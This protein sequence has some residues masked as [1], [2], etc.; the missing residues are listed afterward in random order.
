MVL[1]PSRCPNRA[2]TSSY[3]SQQRAHS[4][5]PPAFQTAKTRKLYRIL[6]DMYVDLVEPVFE[7]TVRVWKAPNFAIHEDIREHFEEPG[8]KASVAAHYGQF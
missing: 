4:T 1:R 2:T 6:Y 3:C 5:L 7:R 8:F